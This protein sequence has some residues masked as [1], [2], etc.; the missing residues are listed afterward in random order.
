MT[1][2]RGGIR[3]SPISMRPVGVAAALLAATLATGDELTPSRL[4]DAAMNRETGTVRALIREGADP[5]ALGAYGTPALL[6]VVRYEDLDTARLLLGAGAHPDLP[7]AHRIAPLHL[8]VSNGDADM[9]RLLLEAGADPDLSDGGGETPLFRAA[10]HAHA[11]IA[12][13]L[14]EHGA[15]VDAREPAYSQTALHV[16][17]RSGSLATARLL[18]EHGAGVNARTRAGDVPAFRLPSDNAGSKG[19]GIIRGGWPE[20][21]MRYPVPGAKTPLAYA[22]RRGDLVMTRLLVEAGAELEQTD[23]NGITPL[24]N[25]ILNASVAHDGREAGHFA[26]V[27]YLLERGADVN[28][29]DWYGETPLWAAVDV[30]NLDLTGPAPDNGI[31]RERA[32]GLIERL[33]EA[34]AEPNARIREYPPERR[35]ITRLGSLSWV[36]FTGQTPFL[37]AALA[38]DTKVLRLLLEYGADPGIAT[39]GGTTPLMAA[40]GVNWVVNQTYD[41]G[42]EALLAAVELTHSLGN[43]INAVNSMGL[44]AIHGAANRGSNAIIEYL[45]AEGAVLDAADKEGRTPLVWAE[46]VFLATHPPVRKDA[47]IAL[48]ERLGAPAP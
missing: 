47:T 22:T 36:D 27:E 9:V 34:G 24:L 6:W 39:F 15:D 26:V 23:E 7:N 30:R 42:P 20:R 41:E 25:A 19:V 46:G 4:A 11:A 3:P 32:L 29:E 21:G 33:L 10:R 16:A 1:D 35:F 43:D 38:G 5:D 45:A 8:A 12:A 14:L 40:A 48:L 37:R 17:A 44:S 18:L 2:T 31:D 28:A 13:L